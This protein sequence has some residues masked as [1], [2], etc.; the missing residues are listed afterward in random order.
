LQRAAPPPVMLTKLAVLVAF[1]VGFLVLEPEQLKR[2]ALPAQLPVYRSPVRL[3]AMYVRRSRHW[4]QPRLQLLIRPCP[5]QLPA[6]RGG[7]CPPPVLGHGGVADAHALTDRAVAQ[8]LRREAED[9]LDLSH[10]QPLCRHAPP[11]LLGS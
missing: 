11:S 4:K 5:A 9:L 2:D 3:R 8:P 7:R 1:G 6:H 10:G